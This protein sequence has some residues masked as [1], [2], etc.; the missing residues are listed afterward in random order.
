MEYS[1]VGFPVCGDTSPPFHSLLGTHL[2]FEE[3]LNWTQIGFAKETALE[4]GCFKFE[5]ILQIIC[6]QCENF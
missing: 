1:E 4:R 6:L 5:W 2:N 3:A